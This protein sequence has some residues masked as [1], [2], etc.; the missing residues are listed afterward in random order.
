[1]VRP[2]HYG[3]VEVDVGNGAVKGLLGVIDKNPRGDHTNPQGTVYGDQQAALIQ[4]LYPTNIQQT[5]RLFV[6]Y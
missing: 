6:C 2:G 4:R 1:M 3:A 5:Y